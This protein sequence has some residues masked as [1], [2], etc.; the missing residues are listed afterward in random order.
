MTTISVSNIRVLDIGPD[1]P[2]GV[3]ELRDNALEDKLSGAV[4]AGSLVALAP[5]VSDLH[6]QDVLHSLLL[7]Q[8]AANAK[9][10]RF[11][12]P[13][14][15][16][17]IYRSVMEQTAWVV[18]ESSTMTRYLP[19]VSSFSVANV[20]NDMFRRHVIPEELAYVSAIVNAF[21]SDLSG[22]SQ[23]IFECPS[24]NGGIGNF[25]VILAKEEDGVLNL[26]IVQ[27]SFNTPQ[28]VT[29]LMLEEFT[30]TAKFQVAVL[31]LTQ[32][33]EVYAKVRSTILDR[34]GARFPGSVAFLTLP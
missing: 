16:F 29:R 3:G 28:H 32:N 22:I 4:V 26:H 25:Q 18:G 13:V 31:T 12:D 30:N 34:V 9:A 33:E 7:A 20:V 2:T 5:G 21:R 1:L 15:W 19:Q 24:H 6:Q 27:V 17:R 8:L 10:E 23:L 14:S 11:K